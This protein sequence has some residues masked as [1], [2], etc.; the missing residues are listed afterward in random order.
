MIRRPTWI[1]LALLAV[2]LGATWYWQRTQKGKVEEQPTPTPASRLLDLDTS[3]IRDLKFVDAQ[4]KQLYLRKIGSGTWIM[5]EP[6]RQNVDYEKVNPVVDQLGIAVGEGESAKIEFIVIPRSGG[7]E[8]HR[9]RRRRVRRLV[10][11]RPGSRVR[12]GEERAGPDHAP[13][14]R[15]RD[16]GGTA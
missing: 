3:S 16:G 5:T 12:A 4:G 14:L 7:S 6:V 1:L 13:G 15:A 8:R 10:P 2:L 9:P 11:G